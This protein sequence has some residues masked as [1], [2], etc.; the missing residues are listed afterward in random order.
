MWARCLLKH[1]SL[2]E[3]STPLM[4]ISLFRVNLLFRSGKRFTDTVDYLLDVR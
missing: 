1:E 3:P 4:F 2:L